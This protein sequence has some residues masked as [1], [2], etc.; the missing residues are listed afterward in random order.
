MMATTAPI[1]EATFVPAAPL[2]DT[3]LV[4]RR[5]QG[6][7]ALGELP[8]Y[9][10]ELHRPS[11]KAAVA[12]KDVLGK[13]ACVH[14]RLPDNSVRY[15]HGLVTRFERGGAV[16]SFDVYHV[17]LRPWLWLLTLGADCR[18]FQDKGADQIIKLVFEDY[19]SV[20][21]VQDMCDGAFRKRP[22]TVQYRESDFAF[23]SRLM[24]EEGIYYYFKH[25]AAKHT[26]VLCNSARAHKPIEGRKL[27]WGAVQT[28]HQ[29]RTDIVAA[30]SQANKLAPLKYTHTDFA[31][32][33]TT[34]SLKGDASRSAGYPAPNDL[35]VFDYPGGY[36]DLAMVDGKS[37]DKTQEAKRLAQLRVDAFESSHVVASGLTPCRH[38]A[39][40]LTFDFADYPKLGDDAGAFL[41]TAA[42]YE[43][44]FA[45]QEA[46]LDTQN[47]GFSCRFDA[48]PKAVKFQPQPAA[49]RPLVHGPQTATVVGPAGDEIHT[50]KYGRVKVHFHW[51]RVGKKD[52][53]TSCWVRVSTPWASNKFGGVAL[54]R[55]GDEVVV[56]FLEGNP[57]R[58]LITGRV[59]NATNMPPWELPAHATVSGIKSRSSKGGAAANANELRFEDAKGSEELWLRAEKD[60]HRW[61]KN[62]A[63]DT[64]EH[65]RS[66]QTKGNSQHLVSGKYA[67]EVTKTATVKVDED[68][69]AKFGAD[70]SLAVTGLLGAKV[71][72]AIAVK[73]AKAIA[74][75]AGAALD[76]DAGQTIKMTGGSSVHIKGLGVV[77]DGGTSLTIK[78]GSGSVV[79]DAGGVTINGAMVKIN[80]GGSAGPANAADKASP[81]AP[82]A[83]GAPA[84]NKDPL[85]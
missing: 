26:L 59:Y 28:E 54:P 73:G 21:Q 77:I 45:G 18:I 44:E 75:T 42:N 39:P 63:F 4:F 64:V 52:G 24:E 83:P 74:V 61:V 34:V 56:S 46:N 48:V 55:I 17:E 60:Y 35:E 43:I 79:L 32:E 84:E 13:A 12:P 49:V 11:K 37:G 76:V 81:A 27:L 31:A 1:P 30:W 16:G 47:A 10:I 51:D 57:D 67:L 29:L 20:M 62:D 19:K 6:V 2:T 78:A 38:V 50:D 15:L 70:F 85:A 66:S 82:E 58:P 22:Y 36:E 7:E 80:C 40:G 41:V 9:R 69:G 5:L 23:V 14:L 8:E 3:D 72:D 53:T 68:V 25:E 65:D 33:A 71:D